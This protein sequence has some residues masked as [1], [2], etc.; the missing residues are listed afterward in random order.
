MKKRGFFRKMLFLVILLLIGW[1][2]YLYVSGR[3]FRREKKQHT[4]EVKEVLEAR[5]QVPDSNEDVDPFGEDNIVRILFVG[6]DSRAGDESAHC[7]AIQLI[8]ID[9]EHDRIT[10]T[11]VPRGTYSPLPSGKGTTS[12]DYYV[13]NSCG[14]GGLE[15][16]VKQIERILGKKADYLVFA[17]FSEVLGM[18]RALKLPTTETLQWLRNRQG[19]AI[20]EPQRARN[21]S[22]FLKKLFVDKVP[23]ERKKVDTALQYLLYTTVDTNLTFA[24]MGNILDELIDMNLK[25]K[26]ENIFLAMRPV[27]PVQDIEYAPDNIEGHLEATLGKISGWL[28][29]VDYSNASKEEVQEQLL[30]T[31][32]K[33]EEN[34]EFVSW[35]FDNHVWLQVEDAVLRE[36]IHFDILVRYVENLGDFSKQ[37]KYI[38]DYILEMDYWGNGY[39]RDIGWVFL[40]RL[41]EAQE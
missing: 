28:P 25:E 10:I 24:E 12:T 30:E 1:G 26:P 37:K 35:S 6:L 17:G 23:D 11:A 41:Q 7:D 5:L 13:S 31:I 2:T 16:G 14:L 29:R 4:E 3:D 18:L 15:Y 9:K 40:E 33:N 39:W 20:G 27:H 8:E 32:K 38:E 21:H 34:P 22:N 19:Y 36:D